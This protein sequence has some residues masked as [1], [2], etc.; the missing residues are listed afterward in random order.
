MENYNHQKLSDS[1][2]CYHITTWYCTCTPALPQC[3]CHDICN[4]LKWSLWYD[5]FESKV[6][7]PSNFY[8]NWKHTMM[9]HE[10]DDCLLHSLS[11]LITKEKVKSP[12]YLHFVCGIHLTVGFP[13]QRASNADIM[14]RLL[15]IVCLLGTVA[16]A[17]VCLPS[18]VAC[19]VYSSPTCV[20]FQSDVA[21][22][23]ISGHD[24]VTTWKHFPH[25][26]PFVRGI[27]QSPVDSPHKGAVG[28]AVHS[29]PTCVQFQSDV[30][31]VTIFLNMMMLWHGHTF[32]I[33]GA[34]WGES[35]GHRWI[36]LTKGQLAVLFT[37]H[38]LLCNSSQL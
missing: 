10:C 5:L 4:I 27:H 1:I 26:W 32:H 34:L 16:T 24:D 18:W 35:T 29:S 8:Y 23:T 6:K 19:L 37:G 2:T 17:T 20:Q 3:S 14:M 28:C 22:V 30:A 21:A 12:H 33:T 15:V 7:F 36:P 25:N 38:L 9:S 31:A 11:K 13:S